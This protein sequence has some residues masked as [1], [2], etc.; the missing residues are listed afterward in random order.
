MRTARPLSA[1]TARLAARLGAA[2]YFVPTLL[3]VV[4]FGAY[5]SNGDFLPGGDQEGN[6]LFSVN[7]LVVL[8]LVWKDV[9]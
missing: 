7:L 5:V 6:M 1:S 4:C 3:F 8:E 9:H 2:K